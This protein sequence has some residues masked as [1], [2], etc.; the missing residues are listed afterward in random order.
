MVD[1][2]VGDKIKV[3]NI[4]SR[5][6]G[7]LGVVVEVFPKTLRV[8]F[9]GINSKCLMYKTSVSLVQPVEALAVEP[10]EAV[11]EPQEPVEQ[12]YIVPKKGTN[13]LVFFKQG[14][15]IAVARLFSII[16]T[17]EGFK[18][19]APC[20]A[21]EGEYLGFLYHDDEVTYKRPKHREFPY[22]PVQGDTVTGKCCNLLHNNYGE[23]L[24]AKGELKKA[25]LSKV[26]SYYYSHRWIDFDKIKLRFKQDKVF[27]KPRTVLEIMAEIYAHGKKLTEEN[28]DNELLCFSLVQINNVGEVDFQDYLR[29]HCHMA[30]R[31]MEKLDDTVKMYG[32]Q[33]FNNIF[34]SPKRGN[35]EHIDH[36][37]VDEY[38]TWVLQD[39]IW[40]DCFVDAALESFKEHGVLVRTDIPNNL[41]MCAHY[42][43][44]YSFEYPEFV[45]RFCEYR[46]QV[47]NPQLA[48]ILASILIDGKLAHSMGHHELLDT[49]GMSLKYAKMFLRGEKPKPINEN[50]CDNFYYSSVSAYHNGNIRIDVES[51]DN[52][53]TNIKENVPIEIVETN[54][55]ILGLIKDKKYLIEDIETYVEEL[56]NE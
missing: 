20:T 43:I 40:A 23:F 25:F 50:Y 3:T 13:V 6:L 35:E 56:L 46:K 55:P 32:F 14:E 24:D 51:H 44:R 49:Y 52:F 47:K 12:E 9:E 7:L 17:K 54:H 33:Y 45:K 41:F 11:E 29:G 16:P 34:Y 27:V 10:V 4:R 39:S 5:H 37:Y 15:D 28:V 21:L 48:Y 1:F 26:G 36:K 8:V 19:D 2:K 30:Y 38:I 22:W 18:K 42:A 53:V 31:R